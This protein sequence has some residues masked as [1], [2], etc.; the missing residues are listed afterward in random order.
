MSPR[1]A[2]DPLAALFGVDVVASAGALRFVDR[3]GKPVCD[4]DEDD[5]VSGKTASLVTLTRAQESELP[6]EIALSF[7]DSENDFQMARVSSRRLEG[8]S[9][10]QSEAQAAVMTHRANAQ[11]LAESWLQ[12]LWIGRETAEFTL[13]PGLLALQ[14]GDLVRLGAAGGGRLFQ[15]QRITDGASRQ[16]S[17]RAADASVYDAAAPLLGRANVVSPKMVGPPRS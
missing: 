12:D 4:I 15:I 13:R 11:S 8:R 16:V 3:R 14:P 6:Q 2:I 7:C 5:L 17:A 10:R 9:A 1:E